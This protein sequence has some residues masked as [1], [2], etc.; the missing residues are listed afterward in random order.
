M[1]EIGVWRK[2]LK[3]ESLRLADP[4]SKESYQLWKKIKKVK[5]R[6]RPNKG[7]LDKKTRIYIQTIYIANWCTYRTLPI[8]IVS[9]TVEALVVAGHRFSILHR[10]MV[11][12]AMQTTFL[13]IRRRRR[14][15][16]RGKC[17]ESDEMMNRLFSWIFSSTASTKSSSTTDDRLLH[18][19]SCKFSRP[20]LK[21]LTHLRIIES[22][23]ACRFCRVLTMVYNTKN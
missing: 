13:L 23:M 6:P 10:R 4:P 7:I 11:P 20:S 22:L 16:I 17:K 21:C 2:L 12:P 9:N 14:R 8:D 3:Y 5:K 19:S 15:G 18:G 1:G